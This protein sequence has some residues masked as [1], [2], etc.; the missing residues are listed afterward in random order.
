MSLF[1]SSLTSTEAG[2]DVATSPMLSPMKEKLLNFAPYCSPNQFM[3]PPVE[4]FAYASIGEHLYIYGGS[5]LDG[6]ETSD[7]YSF[8]LKSGW[9]KVEIQNQDEKPSPRVAAAMT[10]YKKKLYVFGGINESQGW[11]NDFYEFDTETSAWKRIV[12]EDPSKGPSPRD[13]VALIAKRDKIYLYGG[14]GPRKQSSVTANGDANGNGEQVLGTAATHNSPKNLNGGQSAEANGKKA[15]DENGGKL[16][17]ADEEKELDAAM[18]AAQHQQEGAEFDY[19]DD[20]YCFDPSTGQWSPVEVDC[21]SSPTMEGDVKGSTPPGLAAYTVCALA[22]KLLY[23]GGKTSNGERTNVVFCFALGLKKWIPL[24]VRDMSRWPIGRSFHASAVISDR[25]LI[26]FGGRDVDDWERDDLWLLDIGRMQ[27]MRARCEGVGGVSA[28]CARYGH[29]LAV[30]PDADSRLH[31]VIYGGSAELDPASGVAQDVLT[32]MYV[33]P[34]D[35]VVQACVPVY[36]DTEDEKEAKHHHHSFHFHKTS[37]TE[38]GESS[39]DEPTAP[40]VPRCDDCIDL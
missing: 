16:L 34:A 33:V 8:T 1:S 3:P 36:G 24:P 35:E 9:Q 29:A 39:N 28:P 11:M 25:H 5:D 27:W 6:Q 13:K 31:V 17:E 22:D 4:G 18:K 38:E 30:L 40:K 19:F 12:N 37:P 14:F 7:L 26:T 23:F 15:R 32:D 20:F 21:T 10:A 2:V